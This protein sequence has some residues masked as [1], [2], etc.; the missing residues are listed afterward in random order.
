MWAFIAFNVAGAIFLYWL[1]RVPKKPKE[2]EEPQT[3]D[4]GEKGNPD[5]G[6]LAGAGSTEKRVSAQTAPTI[7]GDKNGEAIG[8]QHEIRFEPSQ[9]TMVASEGASHEK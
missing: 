2:Q 8:G 1:A 4:S 9:N 7:S 5:H 6:T 3:V